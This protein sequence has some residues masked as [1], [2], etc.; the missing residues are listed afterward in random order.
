MINSY[1]MILVEITGIT[2]MYLKLNKEAIEQLP[3][4][5]IKRHYRREVVLAMSAELGAKVF[6]DPAKAAETLGYEA[7]LPAYA[8]TPAEPTST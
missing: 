5:P 7:A 6:D 1:L 8:L 3:T 4:M 2:N